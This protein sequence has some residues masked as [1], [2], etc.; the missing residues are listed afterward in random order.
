LTWAGQKIFECEDIF[1]LGEFFDR[2]ANFRDV[3]QSKVEAGQD[4]NLL[5]GHAILIAY[6]SQVPALPGQHGQQGGLRV[7]CQVDLALR[8]RVILDSGWKIVAAA[9]S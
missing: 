1:V 8:G 4:M 3:V 9:C 7:S 2:G 5:N 6:G